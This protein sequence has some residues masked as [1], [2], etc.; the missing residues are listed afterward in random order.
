M[1]LSPQSPTASK[2]QV[3]EF[4]AQDQSLFT[5][6]NELQQ[7][8]AP[9]NLISISSAYSGESRLPVSSI[10]HVKDPTH[11]PQATK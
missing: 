3:S 6:R 7:E 5:I 4:R 2:S 10:R 9:C 8:E 11:F 1:E